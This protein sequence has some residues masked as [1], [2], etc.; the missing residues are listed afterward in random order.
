M[1]GHLSEERFVRIRGPWRVWIGQVRM[2][3]EGGARLGHL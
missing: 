1:T 2:H 3:G